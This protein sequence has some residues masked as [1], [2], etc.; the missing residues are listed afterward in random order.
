MIEETDNSIMRKR[1]VEPQKKGTRNRVPA[2]VRMVIESH[3]PGPCARKGGVRVIVVVVV[4]VV[5]FMMKKG[6]RMMMWIGRVAA[7]P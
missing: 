4:V 3:R 1:C 5:L 7:F 6:E 2:I